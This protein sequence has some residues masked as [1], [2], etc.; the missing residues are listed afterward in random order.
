MGRAVALFLFIT[1]IS[2]TVALAADPVLT[3]ST[4]GKPG[5]TRFVVELFTDGRL[6]V[7]RDAPPFTSEGQL[8]KKTVERWVSRTRI[9]KLLRLAAEAKDFAAG[10]GEV[11]DGTS[12]SMVL[13]EEGKT[14]RRN[15]RNAD[16][17]PNG[18]KAR[19]LLNAINAIV[20]GE[21]RVY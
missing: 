9:R 11:S 19:A 21:M 10:C 1:C 16:V 3:L 13:V 8:T 18:R 12:A 7:E 20:P 15:C 5:D 17:W 14:T 2:A 4:W 6:R